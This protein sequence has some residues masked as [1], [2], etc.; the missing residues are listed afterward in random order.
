MYFFGNSYYY[1][2][3]PTGSFKMSG[4]RNKSKRSKNYN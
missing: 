4:C 2:I 1:G 3:F